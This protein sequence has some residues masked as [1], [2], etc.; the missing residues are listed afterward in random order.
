[1]NMSVIL[2]VQHF[3]WSISLFPL[4]CGV[5]DC[6]R[7]HFLKRE[8]R[9][10]SMHY[11][12]VNPLPI[13][14]IRAPPPPLFLRVALLYPWYI[15]SLKTIKYAAFLHLHFWPLLSP[16][17]SLCLPLHLLQVF[18]IMFVLSNC[19]NANWDVNWLSFY[20]YFCVTMV[21]QGCGHHPKC[22]LQ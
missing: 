8:T 9:P 3:P 17:R 22:N 10:F 1:M 15:I 21:N 14:P 6:N 2:L 5:D 19:I 11:F 20:A 16:V 12:S 7:N 13:S 18:A 4:T